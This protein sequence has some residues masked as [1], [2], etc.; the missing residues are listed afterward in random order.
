[1]AVN[2]QAIGD[3]QLLRTLTAPQVALVAAICDKEMSVV[4]PNYLFREGDLAGALYFVTEGSVTLN[5]RINAKAGG[6]DH[7]LVVAKCLAN[8]F[9]GWSALVADERYTLSALV[10]QRCSVVTLEA[11]RFKVLLDQ[12]PLLRAIVM[13]AL[14]GV[15]SHRFRQLADNHALEHEMLTTEVRW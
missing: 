5:K 2:P 8:E 1:M 13:T 12:D 14:A 11:A 6:E 3:N 7:A 4:G 9:V 10:E 15:I